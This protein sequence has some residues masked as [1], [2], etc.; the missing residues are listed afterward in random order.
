MPLNLEK[1]KMIVTEVHNAIEGALSLVIANNS[2][3]SA[4]K[5]NELRKKG[6]EIGVYL[7]VVRNT[8]LRFIVQDTPFECI[9]DYLI[10]PTLIAFSKKHPGTAA[11]LLKEFGKDNIT[12]IRVGVFESKII[13]AEKIELLANLPSYEEAVTKLGFLIQE[14]AIGKLIRIIVASCKCNV[15][16]KK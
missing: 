3:I 4:N 10:G 11:R 12:F 1:K 16:D 7:R 14:I 13:P 6:R 15:N 5:M 8:L 2:G 9:K